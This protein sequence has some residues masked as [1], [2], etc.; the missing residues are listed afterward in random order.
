MHGY[1]GREAIAPSELA[2][3]GREE[4]RRYGGEILAGRATA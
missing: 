1:L 4:V 3:A 2:A